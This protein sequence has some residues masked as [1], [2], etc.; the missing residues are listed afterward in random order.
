MSQSV[1]RH[2]EIL[3]QQ[4]HRM[5]SQAT[6][7]GLR[8]NFA[9]MLSEAVYAKNVLLCVGN[10]S[11][12]EAVLG[13]TPP[14]LNVIPEEAEGLAED[15][16]AFRLRR[17]AIE[18]MIQAT[19]QSKAMRAQRHNTRPAGELTDLKAGDLVEFW[20]SPSSKDIAAWRGPA[21]VVDV[22]SL[23]DGILGIRWQGRN[24]L[25]RCQDV[26]RALV[27]LSLMTSRRSSRD[28]LTL[29]IMAVEDHYGYSLRLGWLYRQGRW[30]Q[31]E[32]NRHHAETLLAALHVASNV[33]ML[34]GTYG[35]RYG[36][37][38]QALPGVNCDETFLVWWRQGRLHE[39]HHSFAKG[40]EHVNVPRLVGCSAEGISIMQF[41]LTDDLSFRGGNFPVDDDLPT[42]ASAQSSGPEF[43]HG[44]HRRT[45]VKMLLDGHVDDS[46]A[47]VA[48]GSA[49]QF[50]IGTPDGQSAESSAAQTDT[51]EHQYAFDDDDFEEA[52]DS[53]ELSGI[54][55]R[56]KDLEWAFVCKP[57][58]AGQSSTG[59]EQNFIDEK[60]VLSDLP[61]FVIPS[62]FQHYVMVNSRRVT[63]PKH[64][65]LVH[66]PDFSGSKAAVFP[67]IERSNNVLTRE[68]ALSEAGKCKES[69]VAELCRWDKH[70]AWL[71]RERSSCTNP[72]TSKWV[73]KWKDIGGERKIKARLV[74]QGFKDQQSTDNFAGTTSRWGQRLVSIF[75]VQFG[76]PLL[77]ADISEAFLRGLTFEELFQSG[78][79]SEMRSVQLILPQGSEEL[80]RT[81]PGMEDFNPDTECLEL[82]KPG[83]GLKDA[84]RLWSLALTRVLSKVG[85]QPVTTD[86][87]LFAKH[88]NDARLQVLMSVHVDDLK[89]TGIE[90]E[91]QA[92]MEVL[93]QEFDQLKV[94]RDNFT[95]L[96]LRHSLN[97]DGSREISQV[98]Y[99]GEL[100]TIDEQEV[101]F[102]S[103]EQQVFQQTGGSFRSLLGG[104]A[105]VVQTRPDVAIYISALQRHLQDPRAV[106]VLNANR[107][108]RYLKLHPLSMKIRRVN[109]PW[110]LIVVS[111]SAYKSDTQD[112]LAMRS[113]AIFL[114]DKTGLRQGINNVQL[115]DFVSKKQTRVCR[116][117]FVAELFSLLDLVGH[118]INI[119]LAMTE[120]L[121]GI[122]GVTELAKL[123]E[124]GEHAVRMTAVIDAKSV[125]ESVKV[126][127]VKV[128]TDQAVYIHV[129]RLKELCRTQ[130]SSLVWID[131]RD[132]IADGLNKG[133]VERGPLQQLLRDAQWRVDNPLVRHQEGASK[134]QNE[135]PESRGTWVR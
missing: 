10:H 17:I 73:L 66:R 12:F 14:L 121:T 39:W 113:G 130:L 122:K 68:E 25:C 44:S 124:R 62:E 15:R 18:A 85:L 54:R 21:T 13:R 72:L 111:D 53:W 108:L 65:E 125:L 103:P 23:C 74:A 30:L 80:L 35:I 135:Q 90:S 61:E 133:S 126:K 64:S 100:K 96:G 22:T 34:Q 82:L 97:A 71:R 57:P 19:A 9:E 47:T 87:Q 105:W 32:G 123:H 11:P 7:D 5:E 132:M 28:P 86:R 118:G 98:H 128:P 94:E 26:R 99:V 63:I 45:R 104:L 59:M 114:A 58:E 46:S 51:E 3:R 52:D 16:D 77:S 60:E 89:I 95:R 33:F 115:V 50:D 27:Y 76:W 4:L 8:V 81:I 31:C 93:N 91:I 119:S 83:F 84:P 117:T 88:S 70:K 49:Q 78:H 92:V 40:T 6:E 41:L 2:H 43:Q 37:G 38:I 69:M 75:A 109:A 134:T 29:L 55:R 106:D 110:Q 120:I 116:S 42:S 36:T 56:S 107:V 101:K 79:S 129:L 24:L 67:V 102:L 127:E 20:R 112:C 48:T 131:T 1:E